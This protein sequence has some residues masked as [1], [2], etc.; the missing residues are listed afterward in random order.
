MLNTDYWSLKA[1]NINNNVTTIG[2]LQLHW[3]HSQLE[4]ANKSQQKVIIT[5]HIPPG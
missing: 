5:G 1:F 2:D 4:K 3:L